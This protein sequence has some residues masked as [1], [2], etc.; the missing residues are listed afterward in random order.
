MDASLRR[1]G[2]Q[3]TDH[4]LDCPTVV[5]A[6]HPDDETLGCGG[7]ICRIRSSGAPVT[8]LVLTDGSGSHPSPR[9]AARRAAE[10][11]A[12]AAVLGVD[13][14][15]LLGLPDGSLARQNAEVLRRRVR[16]VLDARDAQTVFVTSARDGSA[17]HEA[18]ARIVLTASRPGTRLYEYPVWLWRHWPATPFPRSRGD[19]IQVGRSTLRALGGLRLL[20]Q[21]TCVVD[22]AA[23]LDRKRAAL[24][25]HVSQMSAPEAGRPTLTAVGRGAFL[26]RFF[27]GIEVFRRTTVPS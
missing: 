5:V 11:R 22:V 8:I 20:R 1:R 26:D 7:T 6:P 21:Y 3:L 4:D 12:A 25:C 16:D 19:A 2:R 10:V 17:D 13:D 9:L 18:A 14:V 24:A 15:V 23:D 27:T